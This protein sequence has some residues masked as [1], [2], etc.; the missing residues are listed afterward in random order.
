MNRRE[1]DVSES[2]CQE[3]FLALPPGETL[4][5]D[6]HFLPVLR[7]D[8]DLHA[9]LGTPGAALG[10]VSLKISLRRGE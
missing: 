4:E 9:A 1:S 3:K 7:D 5:L 8:N 6:E 2:P 10:W